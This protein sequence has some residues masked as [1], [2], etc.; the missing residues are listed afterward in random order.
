MFERYV[1][2]MYNVYVTQIDGASKLKHKIRYN[3]ENV[4]KKAQNGRRAVERKS[5]LV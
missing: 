3:I 4:K 2:E 5:C 1:I